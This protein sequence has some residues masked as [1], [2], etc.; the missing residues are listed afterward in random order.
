M[1]R[2]LEFF[3]VSLNLIKSIFL[4]EITLHTEEKSVKKAGHL[5]KLQNQRNPTFKVSTAFIYSKV[6]DR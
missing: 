5:F 3:I 6:Y 4:S 2:K 1:N